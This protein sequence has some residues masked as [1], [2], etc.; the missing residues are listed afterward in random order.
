[1]TRIKTNH[2]SV[3]HSNKITLHPKGLL[4]SFCHVLSQVYGLTE[5]SAQSA[6]P[7]EEF[8]C[9]EEGNVV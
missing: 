5:T 8:S 4:I 3:L 2:D 7:L 1:M 9:W 6:L